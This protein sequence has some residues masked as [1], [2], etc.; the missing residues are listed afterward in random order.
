MNSLQEEVKELKEQTSAVGSSGEKFE[1]LR[2][3][4]QIAERMSPEA[5]W[6]VK[7][8]QVESHRVLPGSSGTDKLE[9]ARC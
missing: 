2:T 9:G 6:V 8:R 5:R 3:R 4:V 7:A 1:E